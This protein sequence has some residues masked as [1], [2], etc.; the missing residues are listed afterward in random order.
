MSD[1]GPSGYD[2]YFQVKVALQ[3]TWSTFFARHG[4]LTP[5]QQQAIPP[6]LAGSNTLV[7][8]PTASG[9]TEAVLAPL[10]E[11]HVLG[12]AARQSANAE[13][14]RMQRAVNH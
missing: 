2:G 1:P 10:L 7:I 14:G 12:T 11:R 8:A 13:G 3:H 9:K 5:V 6:I 4:G